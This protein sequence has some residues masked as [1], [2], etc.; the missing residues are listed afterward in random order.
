MRLWYFV[1]LLSTLTAG[2]FIA[3]SYSIYQYSEAN[4]SK[5]S[6]K[7]A[8]V[9]GARVYDNQ[10]SAAFKRRLNAAIELYRTGKIEII[11]V[12]GGITHEN[13]LSEAEVGKSYLSKNK[14]PEERILL[15][16]HSK[17]TYENIR[18]SKNLLLSLKVSECV[19][20]TD[21]L[22]LKRAMKIANDLGLKAQAYPVK[23]SLQSKIDQFQFLMKES[24][25]YLNYLI[26]P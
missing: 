16:A 14:I 21:A 20:V 8:L 12:S 23:N 24:L 22:H 25:A 9:L 11:L 15:E 7:I 1:I 13:L 4:F 10:P 5:P 17:N 2:G 19:I 26:W 18:F 3:L 6:A